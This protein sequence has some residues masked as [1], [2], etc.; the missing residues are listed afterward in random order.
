MLL[1]LLHLFFPAYCL[2]CQKL[3]AKGE[4]GVCNSCLYN[5]PQTNH[6]QVLDNAMARKFYGRVPISY[7]MAFCRYRR[8]GILQKLVHA[9]KYDNQPQMGEILGRYYGKILLD[10]P[11]LHPFQIIMPVPLH[12]DKLN[13]RGY[14]QSDYFAQGLSSILNIPWQSTCFQRIKPTISQTGQTKLN[15]LQNLANAFYV[16]DKQY[17]QGQ[18]ILLVDDIITTGATL[19]A[20]AA[21]LLEAG[22]WQVSVATIGITE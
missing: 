11:W 9:L 21:V 12:P 15:R 16:E 17:I 4:K 19:E 8:G 13:K 14:N 2:G 22:A 3:L 6:H 5:L 7:A 18:H 1:D 20:C 10:T